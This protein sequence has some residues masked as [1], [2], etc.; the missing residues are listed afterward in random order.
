MVKKKRIFFK[1]AG[2]KIISSK[3]E[4]TQYI[5]IKRQKSRKTIEMCIS[6]FPTY[7]LGKK[8]KYSKAPLASNT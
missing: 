1:S 6:I 4:E 2:N 8:P 7:L 5:G 3:N